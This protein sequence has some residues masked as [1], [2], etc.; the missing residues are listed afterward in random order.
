MTLWLV[1]ALMTFAAVFAVLWPLSRQTA[2]LAE[3]DAGADAAVYRDQL[4]EI[5]RDRRSRR[6]QPEE[7]D[8]A[9]AE[10]ARRL[11]TAAG[12][13][14]A[15]TDQPARAWR[16]R[17]AMVAALI[18]LPLGAVS[19][20]LA[21]GSPLIPGE[22]LAMRSGVPTDKRPITALV[23]DVERH[24]AL[25]PD[26]ARGWEVVA[27]VY[28]R[29]GRFDDA[30]KAR[31]NVL[32]IGGATAA[33]ESDLGEA[34]VAAADGVVTAEAKASFDRSLALDS[35]DVRARYFLGLAAEQDG[36]RKD[37]EKLW[38]ALLAEAPADAAWRGL[39]EQ[40]LA[41]SAQAP[42]PGAGPSAEDVTAAEGLSSGERG[43]MIQG[44]VS[45]LAERLE[46]D[47]GDVDDWLKLIRA[48]GVL[49]E[50]DKARA[51]V[52]NALKALAADTEKLRRVDD[53]AKTLR[54]DE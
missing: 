27:P 41:R 6:L 7:A 38:Q 26:D 33:R 36:R 2:E 43:A 5:E 37:A 46:K 23:A 1:L 54:L 4:D 34:L 21:I 19:F 9:R 15:T 10:V 31:R 3:T 47:G 24:L 18:A 11:I 28:M 16:R 17:A 42:A 53:L 52:V 32:R 29:L 30:V 12:A 25:N 40:S 22:P 51:T 48:Y 14:H 8:A 20:Y 49:G 45:R 50:N 35:K 13:A 39:V 44:M